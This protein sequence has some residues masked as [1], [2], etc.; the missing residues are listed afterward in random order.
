MRA[1]NIFLTL[2]LLVGAT[3]VEAGLLALSHWQFSRYRQRQ[4]ALAEFATRP[5]TTVTGTFLSSQTSALENQPNPVNPET[6]GWRILTPLA[7]ASGTILVDRG[8]APPTY[9]APNVPN[10][11]PFAT[12][13]T[14]TLQGIWQPLPVRHGWLHGPDVTT[15]PR[16]LAFLNPTLITSATMPSHYLITRTPESNLTAIP[17][18]LP[19]PL[20]HLSYALQW[21]GMAIAFPVLCGIGWAKNRRRS[22]P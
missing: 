14:V 12:S 19:A 13:Q 4:A 22:R 1:P 7:T 17:P 8:W 3:G 10:F 15:H 5:A 2:A 9:L 11:A 20:R 18:P 16:L 6:I 21:L